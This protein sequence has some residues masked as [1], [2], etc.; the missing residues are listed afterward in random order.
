MG[1]EIPSTGWDLGFGGE[2]GYFKWE[3]IILWSWEVNES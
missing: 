2:M 3:G 1:V